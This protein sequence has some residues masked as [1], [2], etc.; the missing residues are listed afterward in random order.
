[1]FAS[2]SGTMLSYKLSIPVSILQERPQDFFIFFIDLKKVTLRTTTGTNQIIWIGEGDN[3]FI[4]VR[5]GSCPMTLQCGEMMR[6]DPGIRT[7]ATHHLHEQAFYT[8][9]CPFHK[10]MRWNIHIQ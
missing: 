10:M 5:P 2:S 1:M 6:A 8:S 4:F 9:L 7:V 3:F